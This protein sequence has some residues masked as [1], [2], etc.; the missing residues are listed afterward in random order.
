MKEHWIIT[1]QHDDL[2]SIIMDLAIELDS[3][4]TIIKFDNEGEPDT[5]KVVMNKYDNGAIGVRLYEVE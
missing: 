5:V 1:E 2:E 3:K 4:V